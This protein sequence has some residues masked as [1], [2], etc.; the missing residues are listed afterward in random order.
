LS[1]LKL[2]LTPYPVATKASRDVNF[3]NNFLLGR[4]I[5]IDN[6]G[7]LQNTSLWPM[8]LLHGKAKLDRQ[9]MDTF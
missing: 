8:C 5:Y 1:S 9:V 4:N 3:V 6:L 2:H 7:H